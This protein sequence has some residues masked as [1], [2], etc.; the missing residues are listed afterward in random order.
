MYLSE[1]SHLLSTLHATIDKAV[2][3]LPDEALE[4]Q[5]GAGMNSLGVLLA[6]TLGAERFWIG[7]VAGGEPSGRVRDD[8]FAT[9]GKPVA[10][11]AEQAQ[12]VL[13]HSQ[14]VLARLMP[15]ELGKLVRVPGSSRAVTVAWAILHALEHTALHTGHIEITRQLWDHRQIINEV[16]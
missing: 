5:P 3:D 12:A 2:A 7:D 15:D 6:H 11:F 16:E 14:Q 4:W 10:Y 1:I 9:T 8:E 13:A